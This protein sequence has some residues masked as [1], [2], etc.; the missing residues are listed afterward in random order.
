MHPLR[1][2]NAL[3]VGL[4]VTGFVLFTGGVAQAA[5]F[6]LFQFN[7]AGHTKEDGTWGPADDIEASLESNG[8]DAASIN[9]MCRNQFEKLAGELGARWTGRFVVTAFAHEYNDNQTRL[10]SPGVDGAEHDFGNAIFVRSA[11]VDGSLIRHALPN[12]EPSKENRKIVC[13]TAVEGATFPR[14]IRFCSTHIAN[15]TA[16]SPDSHPKQ[17][18]Q[19]D[20]VRSLVNGFTLPVV[21]MGDFNEAPIS[22]KLDGIYDQS[23]YGGG[24]SGRFVE[25]DHDTASYGNEPRCRC[26]AWTWSTSDLQDKLDFIFYTDTHFNQVAGWRTTPSTRSDHYILRGQMAL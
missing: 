26:G 21:L 11:V 3:H 22:D 1:L 8:T 20:E 9:E 23:K 5:T 10:C 6:D 14:K 12:P 15:H 4:L 24:A 13:V 2:R 18:E 19:I 16:W 25:T 17:Q 7:M